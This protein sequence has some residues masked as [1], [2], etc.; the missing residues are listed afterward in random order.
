MCI[1]QLPFLYSIQLAVI[2]V[3]LLHSTVVEQL[4]FPEINQIPHET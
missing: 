4:I 1:L 3:V 2:T